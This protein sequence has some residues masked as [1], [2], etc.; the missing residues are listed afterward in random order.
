VKNFRSGR[1]A[2][3]ETLE[4]SS[5]CVRFPDMAQA[6]HRMNY[7]ALSSIMSVAVKA[8]GQHSRLY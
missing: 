4:G 7:A 6:P 3:G 5:E 8:P 2:L 1:V